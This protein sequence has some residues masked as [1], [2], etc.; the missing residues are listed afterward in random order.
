MRTISIAIAFFSA[1]LLSA[2]LLAQREGG[3]QGGKTRWIPCSP[4]SHPGADSR[5]KTLRAL[6]AVRLPS[7]PDGRSAVDSAPART[8]NQ[9]I[10]LFQRR[11]AFW[12]SGPVLVM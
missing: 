11:R 6:Q 4:T 5:E 9:R 10:T 8:T 1:A 3:M 2:S 7:L 12:P